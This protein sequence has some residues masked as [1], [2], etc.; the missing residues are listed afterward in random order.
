MFTQKHNSY[1]EYILQLFQKDEECFEHFKEQCRQKGISI[2]S[3]SV[4]AK[5]E[6]LSQKIPYM[7]IF[8]TNEEDYTEYE[9]D[10]GTR[11][12]VKQS[13]TQTILPI[14]Y[15]T[16]KLFNLDIDTYYDPE[17][18][19]G[20]KRADFDFYSYFTREYKPQITDIVI[21]TTGHN[22][23]YVFASSGGYVAIIFTEEDYMNVEENIEKIKDSIV[24]YA[25][26]V[27]KEILSE[28]SLSPLS[29]HIYHLGMKTLNLYGLSRED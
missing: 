2:F 3:I 29:V 20:I 11:G 10:F 6:T 18:Y 15:D 8:V 25:Y 14:W 16:C 19:I 24:T 5:N 27:V 13:I 1:K 26:S 12:I 7:R 9:Q 21:K 28:V 4:T 23:E 22:P 17:M